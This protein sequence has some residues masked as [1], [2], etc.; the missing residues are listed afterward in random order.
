MKHRIDRSTHPILPGL[1]LGAAAGFLLTPALLGMQPG[2]GERWPSAQQREEFQQDERPGEN[3]VF[4]GEQEVPREDR[5]REAQ[6]RI[7]DERLARAA[8]QAERA[9]GAAV[10]EGETIA[11][12]F[13]GPLELSA[14]VDFVARTLGINIIE[15]GEL[16]GKSVQ[17]RA[18]LEIER[19][20][21]LPLLQNLLNDVGFAIERDDLGMYRIRSAGNLAPGELTSRVLRTPLVRPSVAQRAIESQLGQSLGAVRYTPVDELGVL[22]VTGTPGALDSI[23]RLLGEIISRLDE[24]RLIPFPLRYV[25]ADFARDRVAALSGQLDSRSTGGIGAAGGAPQAPG[26]TSQSIDGLRGLADRLIAEQGNTLIFKGTLE[27]AAQIADLIALV[28]RDTRLRVKRYVVGSVAAAAA[29]SGR[30]IGLGE[31]SSLE[32]SFD[33]F[34]TGGFARPGGG[35]QRT[36]G[37]TEAVRPASSGFLVD[38]ENGALIY[39]GTE[40]QHARVE[41]LVEQFKASAAADSIEIRVYKLLYAQATSGGGGGQQTTGGQRTTTTG[42]GGGLGGQN[43]T[44][45][46][47]GSFGFSGGGG[48]TA[49]KGVAE[50]LDELLQDPARQD[51]ARSAFLPGQRGQPNRAQAAQFPDDD[52]IADVIAEGGTG[53]RL[54]ATAENTIIVADPDRNQIIIKAPV[55][56]QEQF[57][58]IIRQLD[59]KQPQILLSAQIVSVTT[60]DA[61][62]WA[63]DVQINAGQFSLLS[64]FGVTGA[65]ENPL[66]SDVRNIPAQSGSPGGLKAGVIRSDYVPVAI[67]ALA[68]LGTTRVLSQ[69][70]ALV[71]DN[72]PAQFESFRE[73]PFSSQSQTN[74]GVITSQGGTTQAGTILNVTPRVS[75]AGDITLTIDLEL[76]DF[77]GDAT[78]G[79]QP[80][81]QRDRFTSN[82]TLP[83]DSTIVIGGFRLDRSSE[84][85][86]KIPILGDIP[87]LGAFFKAYDESN[88]QS[89][90]YV[91]IT[92]QVMRDRSGADLMLITEG[93]FKESGLDPLIPDLEPM[94]MPITGRIGPTWME[95]AGAMPNEGA[96]LSDESWE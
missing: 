53:T 75:G 23:E 38:V 17:F 66:I 8:A 43:D 72:F 46:V 50:V 34:G 13:D 36:P 89:V 67:Q 40:E 33:Q 20:E 70:T 94:A 65:G 61:F 90:I 74:T 35:G 81:V 71:L 51:F 62:N 27:E 10:A 24:Q 80:P 55:R 88:R 18:P 63:A 82:V 79:L 95:N 30:R 68:T 11:L 25:T 16:Q 45:G 14:F 64:S 5:M 56:A 57:A 22:M 32:S 48:S 6:Q 31:V 37:T 86:R 87:I 39:S 73:E 93:P 44:A 83:A 15:P 52:E 84:T 19:D 47:G 41:E 21:L 9:N 12:R 3:P 85:E 76:S 42:G 77:V 49:Q 69:P 29:E 4:E 54:V 91:F 28:D 26:S 96:P 78:G 60:T 59:Q 1:G 7:R 2:V 92:P 58:E